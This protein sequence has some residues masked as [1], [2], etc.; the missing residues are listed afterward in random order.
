MPDLIDS[1][2]DDLTRAECQGVQ[3][4]TGVRPASALM[5]SRFV[6]HPH[7]GYCSRV[8]RG[9][10]GALTICVALSCL[11][12]CSSA[13]STTERALRAAKAACASYLPQIDSPVTDDA[14]VLK[15]TYK[16][17][18]SAAKNAARAASLDARWNSLNT[19]D[20]TMADAWRYYIDVV[21]PAPTD[22]DGK[23]ILT[24]EQAQTFQ[25]TEGPYKRAQSTARAECAKA[26]AT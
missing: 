18:L 8:S 16:D 25:G 24:N 19:A 2:R 20:Q 17:V 5:I 23:H 10:A 11:A 6:G 15:A 13:Q 21:L 1:M 26:D 4:D 14:A 12:A 9:I 7:G 3:V 22:S